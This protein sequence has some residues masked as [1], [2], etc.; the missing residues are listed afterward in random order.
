[1]KFEEEEKNHLNKRKIQ[2]QN[3]V[4]LT[5]LGCPRK[6][7]ENLFSTGDTKANLDRFSNNTKSEENM[8]QNFHFPKIKT[9][10][11]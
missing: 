6:I 11:K 9:T 3:L 10:K 5:A 1:M 4:P 2:N 8:I 7:K